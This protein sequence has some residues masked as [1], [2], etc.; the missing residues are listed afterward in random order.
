MTVGDAIALAGG[1]TLDADRT[2]VTLMRNG[3]AHIKNVELAALVN[4]LVTQ[5]GDQ[6]YVPPASGFFSRNPWVAATIIQSIVTIGAA[7]IVS[8][9]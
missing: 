1:S 2:T 6:L 5:P 9:P 8:N 3:R 7:I 4:T